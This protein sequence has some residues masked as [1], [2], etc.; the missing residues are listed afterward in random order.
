MSTI[1][2]RIGTAVA[3]LLCV[4]SHALGQSNKPHAHLNGGFHVRLTLQQQANHDEM[5]RLD[6]AAI[7]ASDNGNYAEEESDASQSISLGHDSGLA[8]ELLAQALNEQGKSQDALQAYK[9]IADSGSSFPR[10][11]VPY[12]LLLLQT[13]QWAQSVAMYNRALPELGDVGV[14][15]ELMIVHDKDVMQSCSHFLPDDPQP[16]E[17]AVALH[18]AQGITYLSDPGWGRQMRHNE[19]MSEFEEATKLAPNSPIADYYYGV[20]WQKLSPAD[21]AK[22]GTVQQAKAHLQKAVKTG[23]ANVRAAAQK[24]LKQLG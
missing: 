11:L 21:R 9:I 4:T 6:Q 22:F 15:P 23:N 18:I 3:I 8:Q 17:L 5:W 24:V 10:N 20:G 13:G 16:S 14:H 1:K 12:A 7:T 2:Y 19:A